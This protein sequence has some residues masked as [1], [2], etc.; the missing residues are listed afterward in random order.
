MHFNLRPKNTRGSFANDWLHAKHSFSFGDYFDPAHNGFRSLIVMNNDIIAPLG[1]F[2]THP[3][4]NAEIFTYILSGSLKHEDSMG[5]KST[6]KTGDFQ[7]MSAGKGV[8][9]SELNPSS[10]NSTEL[11][12]IWLKPNTLGG[13]PIYADY[14]LTAEDNPIEPRLLFSGCG[15]NESTTIRS[16]A[17]IYYGS[18]KIH[19]QSCL[20]PIMDHPYVW[21][22]ILT[23]TVKIAGHRLTTG[24]GLSITNHDRILSLNCS[25]NS[26]FLAFMLT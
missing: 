23:G 10:T 2:A 3:H 13:E 22:Q 4:Q 16:N 1:G 11:Y 6:I 24:D 5:N 25:A 14:Q 17:E 9:H 19:S 15:R 8:S 20:Y 26:S 21:I 12:Q 7:Y 18:S